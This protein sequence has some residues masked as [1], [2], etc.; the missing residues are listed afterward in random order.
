MFCIFSEGSSKFHDKFVKA[1]NLFIELCI[2]FSLGFVCQRRELH[3][4]TIN[5]LHKC[6]IILAI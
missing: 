6:M 4:N 2:P 5:A 1:N 3:F